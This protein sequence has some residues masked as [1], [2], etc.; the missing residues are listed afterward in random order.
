MMMMEKRHSWETVATSDATSFHAL[1]FFPLVASWRRDAAAAMDP[2]SGDASGQR[3]AK[4]PRGRGGSG[5]GGG[6]GGGRGRRG[7]GRRADGRGGGAGRD[8][9][10]PRQQQQQPAQQHA[11]SQQRPQPGPAAQYHGASGGAKDRRAEASE[12]DQRPT[13]P[14]R[15]LCLHGGRQTAQIFEQRLEVGRRVRSP[16][17]RRRLARTRAEHDRRCCPPSLDSVASSSS[18]MRFCVLCFVHARLRAP[19]SF[20]PSR[21]SDFH[22]GRR[23]SRWLPPRGRSTATTTAAREAPQSDKARG[24]H[25]HRR[26][27]R[28][29]ARRERRRC[30]ALVVRRTH[31]TIESTT[32]WRTSSCRSSKPS[33]V[34]CLRQRRHRARPARLGATNTASRDTTRSRRF[35]RPRPPPSIGAGT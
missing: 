23:P 6:R 27:A 3:G 5:G 13:R 25:L 17:A 35:D 14:L 20:A 10:A 31:K 7:G 16:I 2:S 15:I 29:R 19:H 12:A 9:G 8:G 32:E 1:S 21:A 26:A 33:D 30:A 18:R 28:A 34:A 11:Q 4:N 22:I 24:A